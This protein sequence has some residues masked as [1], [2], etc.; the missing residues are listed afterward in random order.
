MEKFPKISIVTISFNQSAFLEETINS[1]LGQKYPNLEYIIIDGGSTDGSTDIIRKY[2]NQLSYWV[3]EK[4]GGMYEALQKGFNKS[5]GEIM[6]WINSDDLLQPNSLFL[7]A[8][9]FSEYPECNWI[10]GR[11]I[12]INEQGKLTNEC[13]PFNT[14]KYA[15]YNWSFLDEKKINIRAFGTLQN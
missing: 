13:F 15:F 4:D 3:S 9:V 1:V 12:V 8:K 10:E 14:T 2:E 6:G 7:L 11:N 5:S